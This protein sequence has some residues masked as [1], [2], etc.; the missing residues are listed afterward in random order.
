VLAGLTQEQRACIE[1]KGITR[2]SGKPRIEYRRAIF[3]AA[4][5]CGVSLPDPSTRNPA[6]PGGGRGNK[7]WRPSASRLDAPSNRESAT[8]RR[9]GVKVVPV[10]CLEATV[11][12]PP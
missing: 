1:S 11:T 12:V 3:E 2:P 7:R 9:L 5:A 6:K 4:K 8:G 10:P